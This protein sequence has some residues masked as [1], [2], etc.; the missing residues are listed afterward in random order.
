MGRDR[1][2]GEDRQVPLDRRAAH[3]VSLPAAFATS[4]IE[5]D[6]GGA[7]AGDAASLVA[8]LREMV[9]GLDAN[10]PVFDVRTMADFYK[11]RAVNVPEMIVETV[12]AM[13]LIGLLLAMVGLYGLMAY[14][15]ARRTRE[16]GIRMA[17][18]ADR[19][20]VVRMVL[21]QGLTLGVTGLAIGLVASF[22]AESAVNAVFSSTGRDPLAY[23]L[24]APAL[25]AVTLL[26]AWIPA[27]RA[28]LIDPMRA[29]HYE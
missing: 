21:R 23:L 19:G 14:S 5:H 1:G 11:M 12:A 22:A 9:R 26:A 29:L 15:V 4:A 10:Q 18:G 16:I 7:V 2:R 27:R 24:V 17:I 6:P 20:V 8:P 25:L 3:R 13:G 28:S